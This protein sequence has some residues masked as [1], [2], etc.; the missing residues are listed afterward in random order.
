MTQMGIQLILGFAIGFP[1]SAPHGKNPAPAGDSIILGKISSKIA[2][3][4]LHERTEHHHSAA[5]Q[6]GFQEVFVTG[7]RLEANLG[8]FKVFILLKWKIVNTK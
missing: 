2:A 7:F 5:R 1:V 8:S 3:H 4:Q 6:F